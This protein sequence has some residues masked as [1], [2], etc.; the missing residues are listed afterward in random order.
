MAK[1][2][3][4]ILKVSKNAS[5]DE[6]KRAYRKLAHEHHPDKG[7]GEAQKFKEVNEAYEVL[8]DD[9]KRGQYDRFG[10]TFSTQGGQGGFNGFGDF[11][12]FA[13][14][15]SAGDGSAFGGDFASDFSDIFSDIFGG[16]RAS[17]KTRGVDLEM[18]LTI[19]F[20]ESVFGAEKTVSLEKQDTCPH[21]QGE[22]AEKGSKIITCPKCHGQGQIITH[23]RTILGN[24]QAAHIC[25]RCNGTGKIPE[26]P[27]R[28]C[29]GSGVKRQHK[30]L[31]VKIPA[32]IAHGQR[33]RVSG[34]GELGYRGSRPG[35]LYIQINVKKHSEF[36]REG[37][38]IHTEIPVSFYQAALG[39]KLEVNTVD[40]KVDLKIP[41]GTQSGKVLRLRARGIPHLEDAG[42]GDHLIMVRVITPHKLT[43][44]EKALFQELAHERGESV[45]IDDSLWGK[46]KENF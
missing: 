2:Y 30:T 40:G 14:G 31:M 9:T 1:N 5:K 17:R 44:K 46:I 15:F 26:K 32:G 16:A 34:E 8:I 7:G 19:E 39:T 36:V 38:D 20:L 42:R 10:Q 35:D 29:S 37:F 3:Y 6:I 21:C 4:D 28:E 22:G 25:D 27:C 41:A 23:R 43:K 24:M 33:I 12:D 45:D 18:G 13:K 11:S